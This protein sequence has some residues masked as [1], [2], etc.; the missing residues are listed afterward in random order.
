MLL[1]RQIVFYKK[2]ISQAILV[3]AKRVYEA[4]ETFKLHFRAVG[5]NQKIDADIAL[6]GQTMFKLRGDE[7]SFLD[8][9][10]S[11]SILADK[12]RAD[13]KILYGISNNKNNYL[14]NS[15]IYISNLFNK[16]F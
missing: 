14:L 16:V 6:L 9:D 10:R 12:I 13:R 8:R 11:L 2:S 7:V 3:L 4:S 5:L 1:I 15:C